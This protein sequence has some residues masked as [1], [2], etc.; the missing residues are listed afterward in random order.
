MKMLNFYGEF[1]KSAKYRAWENSKEHEHI[2]SMEGFDKAIFDQVSFEIEET[3]G[4]KMQYDIFEIAY[5]FK[6]N[7]VRFA[8]P[9]NISGNIRI[10]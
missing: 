1:N 5:Y 4:R 6:K 10:H 2:G 9:H 3:L 7:M 8:F